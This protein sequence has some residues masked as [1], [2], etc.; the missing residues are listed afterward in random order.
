MLASRP[1]LVSAK[2][3]VK[4]K[5]SKNRETDC[6]ALTLLQTPA[7]R[8]LVRIKQVHFVFFIKLQY[9]MRAGEMHKDYVLTNIIKALHPDHKHLGF[10]P[11]L[12]ERFS[13]R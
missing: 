10:R 8:Q 9:E 11:Q 4:G 3:S 2:R 1:V 7:N 6:H 12:G 13:S 5:F